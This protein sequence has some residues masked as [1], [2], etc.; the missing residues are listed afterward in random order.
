MEDCIDFAL[1]IIVANVRLP[2]VRQ[3][4]LRRVPTATENLPVLPVPPEEALGKQ[5]SQLEPEEQVGGT[6]GEDPAGEGHGERG[7]HGGTGPH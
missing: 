6:A 1:S 7:A 4:R 3:P 2:Q 5:A